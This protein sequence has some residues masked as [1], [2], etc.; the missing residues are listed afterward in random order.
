M[1]PRFLSLGGWSRNTSQAAPWDQA[2]N[3]YP[4]WQHIFII[5]SPSFLL[6]ISVL[7]FCSWITLPSKVCALEPSVCHH[8][9]CLKNPG[10]TLVCLQPPVSL[11]FHFVMVWNRVMIKI[12]FCVLNIL[13]NSSPNFFFFFW[14]EGKKEDSEEIRKWRRAERG[15]KRPGEGRGRQRKIRDGKGLRKGRGRR[16]KGER[17]AEPI[18]LLIPYSRAAAWLPWWAAATCLFCVSYLTTPLCSVFA[19]A[20]CVISLLYFMAL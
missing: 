12:I 6:H 20:Y 8:I 5:H 16:T 13:W 4:A 1:Y 10:E 9:C 7:H 17:R 11:S 19:L 3:L 18:T 14:M 15:E 2:E